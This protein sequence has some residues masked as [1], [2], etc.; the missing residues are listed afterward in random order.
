MSPP[1][2]SRLSP[3]ALAE[4]PVLWTAIPDS[5][6]FDWVAA[7]RPRF[8]A[9]TDAHAARDQLATGAAVDNILRAPSFYLVRKGGGWGSRGSA[10]RLRLY[11]QARLGG[12]PVLARSAAPRSAPSAPPCAETTWKNERDKAVEL[13]SR[14]LFRRAGQALCRSDYAPPTPESCAALRAKH[15]DASSPIPVRPDAPKVIIDPD[16]LFKILSK[17][18]KGRNGGASGWTAELLL[19]LWS[20]EISRDRRASACSRAFARLCKLVVII[21]EAVT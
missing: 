9:L 15:S 6:S 18:V 14:G 19:S 16:K 10:N 17:S 3:S 11:I 20:D 8:A 5:S 7:C 4:H 13:A 12:L 21:L 2:G 1:D